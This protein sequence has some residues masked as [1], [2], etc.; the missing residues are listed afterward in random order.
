MPASGRCLLDANI[1]IA[2]LEGDEAALSNH[3]GASHLVAAKNCFLLTRAMRM[4]LA[5]VPFGSACEL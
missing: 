5:R 4:M 3:S 2:L 1:I